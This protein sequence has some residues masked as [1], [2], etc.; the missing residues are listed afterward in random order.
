LI[1]FGCA[2]IEEP[3]GQIENNETLP[4]QEI[5]GGKIEIT[6]NGRLQSIIHAGYIQTFEKKQVTLFDSGVTVD[7]F[8]TQGKH[9]SVLT[10]A[11]AKIEEKLNLFL[12]MGDVVVVSDSGEV[13]RT[14]R[15][16]WDK[17]TKRVHSDTLVIL[18]TEM[19]SLRG[20]NFESDQNLSSWTIEN[21]TGHTMRRRE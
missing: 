9:S 11:R 15:L 20:Y 16:Y 14:E 18:T 5:W 7:F 8:N 10:S 1:F 6:E 19:D 13:L 3:S 17:D 21:P 4:D 12:A 2:K